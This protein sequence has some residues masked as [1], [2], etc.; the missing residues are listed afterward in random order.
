M[1]TTLGRQNRNSIAGE[2]LLTTSTGQ[3]DKDDAADSIVEW[4]TLSDRSIE[5]VAG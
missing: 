3:E 1:G 2:T 5:R 4:S